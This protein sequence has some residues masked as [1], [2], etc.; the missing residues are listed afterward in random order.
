MEQRSARHESGAPKVVPT[1]LPRFG[2]VARSHDVPIVTLLEWAHM[3]NPP[4]DMLKSAL[5]W[6][7]NKSERRAYLDGVIEGRIQFWRDGPLFGEGY[8]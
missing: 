6:L 2:P 1:D 8:Q 3:V 5:P 4:E 7:S